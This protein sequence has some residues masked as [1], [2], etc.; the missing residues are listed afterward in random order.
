MIVRALDS[1]G[2]WTFG[3]GV[4]NYKSGNLAVAQAIQTRVSSFLGDC[5]FDLGAGIDWFNLLG[6]KNELAL[7]LAISAVILNTTD[8]D[9]NQLVT[10]IQQLSVD[11]SSNRAFSVIYQVVTVYSV[12]SGSFQYDLGGLSQ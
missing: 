7:S 4:N 2:D 8:A 12:L 11:L 3:Q 10:G 9:G 1:N 5:F 6:G